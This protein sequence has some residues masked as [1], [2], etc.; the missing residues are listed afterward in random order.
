[1]CLKAAYHRQPRQTDS[2]PWNDSGTSFPR[3]RSSRQT[4]SHQQ[5]KE[6]PGV[7]PLV[8]QQEGDRK[9]AG[10]QVCQQDPEVRDTSLQ[11]DDPLQ[12]PL[13]TVKML[14]M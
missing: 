6:S 12:V 8:H 13:L 1:M 5:P 2:R 7:Q 11:W 4:P 9:V 10:C 14:V 3:L